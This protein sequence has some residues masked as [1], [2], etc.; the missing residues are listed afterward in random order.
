[1]HSQVE[2]R[3]RF[4]SVDFYFLEMLVHFFTGSASVFSGS[5][6]NGYPL[7]LMD[8]YR[9]LQIFLCSFSQI[10]RICSVQTTWNGRLNFSASAVK[11]TL[12]GTPSLQRSE[13]V[14]KKH[15]CAI[16][17]T[18]SCRVF[19]SFGFLEFPQRSTVEFFHSETRINFRSL[20]EKK[21][22]RC[23]LFARIND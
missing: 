18:A 17:G 3:D 2:R 14:P 22:K 16:S 13:G 7:S 11:R 19:K 6:R 1:M 12:L 15:R 8:F 23:V 9:F 4:L 21:K 5:G 20:T 10:E